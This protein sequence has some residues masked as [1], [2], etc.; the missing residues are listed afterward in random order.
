MLQTKV[1]GKIFEGEMLI[2][3]VYT[4]LTQRFNKIVSNSKVIIENTVDPDDNI[5]DILISMK[6]FA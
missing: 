4:T 3:T 2:R 5:R 6:G 1:N